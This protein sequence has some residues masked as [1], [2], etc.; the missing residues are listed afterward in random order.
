MRRCMDDGMSRAKE[1][2]LKKRED[3]HLI[4][5]RESLYHV[6]PMDMTNDTLL[7]FICFCLDMDG[8]E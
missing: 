6:Q 5:G 8:M 7:V 4:E 1:S 3:I 2:E